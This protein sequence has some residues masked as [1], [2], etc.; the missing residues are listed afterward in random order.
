MSRRR[1]NPP[2]SALC[3]PAVTDEESENDE[4]VFVPGSWL[5]AMFFEMSLASQATPPPSANEPA[6]P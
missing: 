6:A 5:L 3:E 2:Q 4:D 1:V